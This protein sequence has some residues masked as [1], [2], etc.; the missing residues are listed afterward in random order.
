MDRLSAFRRDALVHLPELRRV[1]ARLAPVPSA[2]DDIAQEAF[3]QA[4]RRFD[5]FT[6]G[7]NCRAW[8]YRILF[9]VAQSQRR[10]DARSPFALEDVPEATLAVE[11]G[12]PDVFGRDHVVQDR[13]R[14]VA[15]AGPLSRG[16]P[17]P[18]DHPAR[19]L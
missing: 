18:A 3:L 14:V 12:L 13:P 8:L 6:P 10:R 11:G 2:A 16:S 5:S 7:T 19:L 1:A 9:F 4:W 15:G 17:L